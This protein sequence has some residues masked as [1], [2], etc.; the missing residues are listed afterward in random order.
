M[1]PCPN[2]PRAQQHPN[3]GTP[4]R[5][6]D[7]FAPKANR[8]RYTI[9]HRVPIKCE[10][11]VLCSHE[12]RKNSLPASCAPLAA[13][14]YFALEAG[15]GVE[16]STGVLEFVSD[17]DSQ[18]GRFLSDDPIGLA[19]GQTFTCRS[20]HSRM[21]TYIAYPILMPGVKQVPYGA[22]MCYTCIAR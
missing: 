8:D 14:L 2:R 5:T 7:A 22:R 18:I 12:T 11:S 19:P 10:L 1:C 13:P 16:F 17:Y 15:F 20:S 4:V 3:Q 9:V 6:L 21:R